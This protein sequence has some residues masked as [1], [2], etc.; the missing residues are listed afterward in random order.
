MTTSVYNCSN[1]SEEMYVP[2][3]LRQKGYLVNNG[4]G[5]LIQ[6]HWTSDKFHLLY[7]A[8]HSEQSPTCTIKR[9]LT[10]SRL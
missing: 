10:S 2:M 1:I 7:I 6:H 8:L 3:H 5:I 9:I 4:F